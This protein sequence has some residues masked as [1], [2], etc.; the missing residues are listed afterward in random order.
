MA[1]GGSFDHLKNIMGDMVDANGNIRV[2]PIGQIGNLKLSNNKIKLLSDI[3]KLIRDTSIVTKETKHYISNKYISIKGVDD[4]MNSEER[5]EKRT[6]KPTTTQSKI[7]YDKIKLERIFGI[8]MFSDILS[9][10][11][12]ITSYERA[13]AEQYV[14]YSGKDSIR[15]N[16][17]L[18]I[19]KECM[20]SEVSEE[21]FDE[22]I[23]NISP[24]IK[25]Q[26]KYIEENL[27]KDCVGY[28]NYILNMPSLNEIDMRRVI[29]LRAL[30]SGE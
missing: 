2:T 28:F 22:F 20:R 3:I 10:D 29:R 26:I 23:R 18:D 16:L 14:K 11:C 24:Y 4:L 17:I 27:D 9:R 13:V 1:I 5:E 7:Q 8:N 30:L 21:S 15:K 12:D 6:I 25:S 19:P